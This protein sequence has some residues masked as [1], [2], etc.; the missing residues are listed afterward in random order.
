M[1]ETAAGFKRQRK[2][3]PRPELAFIPRKRK[4]RI[5]RS[6]VKIPENVNYN[7]E[8][9]NMRGPPIK[10]FEEPKIF[11]LHDDKPPEENIFG[12][13]LNRP[14]QRS[15]I[16]PRLYFPNAV[17]KE[18]EARGLTR[19]FASNANVGD[20]LIYTELGGPTLYVT[21]IGVTAAYCLVKND[22]TEREFKL[23]YRD[24]GFEYRLY[25]NKAAR[26]GTRK[27]GSRKLK[28]SKRTRR[29]VR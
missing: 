14:P 8:E 22:E 12:L 26:G 7:D 24:D 10:R 15:A 9:L 18:E 2:N 11:A 1:S 20:R 29:N 17:Q 16:G 3:D 5:Y 27:R 23:P 19:V 28:K 6:E 21:V 4:T 13:P 25:K